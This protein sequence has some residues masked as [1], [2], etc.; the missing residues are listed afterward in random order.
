MSTESNEDARFLIRVTGPAGT[1]EYPLADAMV[2]GRDEG[3]VTLGD[4]AVSRRHLRLEV[5]GD[6]V[7]VTDLDSSNGT[8]VDGRRIE[9]PVTC[10]AGSELRVGDTTIHI[11]EVPP[12]EAPAPSHTAAMSAPPDEPAL[13][14]TPSTSP[15]GSAHSLT[16]SPPSLASG[17]EVRRS[18]DIEIRFTPGTYGAE[19]AKS[20]LS[21]AV[22]ARRNLAGLGSEPWGTVPVVNLID[23]YHDGAEVI[24]S[25]SIVDGRSGEAWVVVSPEAPPEDPHRVL[26]LLFGAALPSADEVQLLIEGFGLHRS[27]LSD[28]DEQLAQSPL[29]P[30]SEIDG[31][32]R[33]AAALSF[34]R[35][36][37][38][39]E[40]DEAVVR[41][42]GA[43]TGRVEETAREVFG[44]ALSQLE[45]EWRRKVLAGEPD[46]KT[47]DFLR[48][49]LK[50]LRPYRLRQLEIFGYMLL[51]LAF[52]AAFPFVTRKLFDTA[53]PSGEFSQVLT[54][55]IGLG[56]AFVVSLVAGVRQAYQ[57]A[58]VSGAVSRDIRQSLFGRVQR[59]PA[60]WYRDH[61]QGDVLSRLFSDVGAVQ[62]GLS[63]AIG[64]GIFQMIS[65]VVT[66]AIMLTIDLW[67]GL[68]VL[69]TAPL[70]GFVYRRMSAGAR[71]RSLAVQENNSALLSVAAE[72]YRANEVVKVFGLAGR[73]ERR[74]SQ[75]SDRL[76]RATRRLQL[77]GGFFGL[78]VN[79][80][81]TLLRLVVLG[82]GAWLIL[83]GRFTTGGLVAFLSIMG[84]VLS[85]V[86][87]LVG[88][89][90]QVQASMGSLVRINEVMDA[91]PE[92]DGAD[93]PALAPLTRELRL[94]GVGLS[95]TPE[96]R[97]L[98]D[99]DVSIPA[100][101]RVAF[102]GPSGSGKSTVLRLLMRMYEPDEGAIL[103]D[104][105]DLR[106]CSLKSWRDQL[107]VVF[108]DSF[109]FDATIRE[110]IAFGR[111]GATDAEV[112]AAAAAAEIDAFVDSLPNGYNSLVGEG[113]ANLSG[114]QRQRVAIARA[115]VR[116]P[117]LLVLDE[118]TSALDPGTERQV[119]DTIAR[120]A[121]HRT[122]VAV[123][124]RLA[125]I[126]DYDRIFVIVDGRLSEQGAHDELVAQRGAYAQLWAEQTGTP[127]PEPEPFDPVAALRRVPFLADI[128]E[129]TIESLAAALTPFAL[130][131]GRSVEE[132]GGLMLVIEG[133]GEVVLSG[134]QVAAELRAGDTFGVGAA[135]GAPAHSTLR[136]RTPMDLLNLPAE[137]LA[138]AAQADPVLADELSGRRSGPLPTG[139]TRLSRLTLAAP[140]SAL[141]TAAAEER[142][143]RAVP[144]P[145]A[146][147]TR[148][149]GAFPRMN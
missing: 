100:G 5:S 126:T 62:A 32:L 71:D 127:M 90:Q 128:G 29:P 50:Y 112:E 149:T 48:L 2:L 60:S 9:A 82:L 35:F 16:P 17:T 66:A 20:Y 59:L 133:I 15:A 11:L 96:R 118:A 93:L 34:V 120:I 106:S 24:A 138:A 42:L 84:E 55:L 58:Y 75:Q 101:S 113:G 23:P 10:A 147:T 33:G 141:T 39:R 52:V 36:L 144:A 105:A 81:M 1:A 8:Y 41:L 54:L 94:A 53:L 57:T 109:L 86:T 92:P 117:Q 76:F 145:T 30:L 102:V 125:S 142:S 91:D 46:V 135:L 85:P 18:D 78:S 12:L 130:E 103:V 56:A 6:E 87:V 38:A 72:S 79:L 89:S 139:G 26:A 28:P 122:V 111:V 132:G 64:Q 68:L 7:V 40:G 51:S 19:V 131:A 13:P 136:G 63:E 116:N 25:G 108:Q 74:F 70:V 107:G 77:W 73:E 14:P 44:A 146:S 121:E 61:P 99:F 67:L 3:D 21:T 65:L 95:Y 148:S 80:I 114:G 88:L 47:G 129:A 137:A 31:E 4:P 124:H 134:D 97:A 104:G 37:A 27:G 43:Q 140:M 69:A 110:N 22:R 143:T 115:L 49:S 119:N 83:E 45:H 123:T 98:D